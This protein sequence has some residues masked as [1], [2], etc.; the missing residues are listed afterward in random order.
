MR[1][2]G[3]GISIRVPPADA[4]FSES[5]P[6]KSFAVLV[7]RGHPVACQGTGLAK[8][9]AIHDNS[10]PVISIQVGMLG[11]EPHEPPGILENRS[12]DRP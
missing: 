2:M 4:G 6:K 10:V 9:V 1:I 8:V 7:D 3:K 11:P 5:D 12:D